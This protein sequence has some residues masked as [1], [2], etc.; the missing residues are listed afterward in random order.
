[1]ST[2]RA[3][4]PRK[5]T[6]PRSSGQVAGRTA[7]RAVPAL[8]IARSFESAPAPPVE[9]PVALAPRR[10]QPVSTPEPI[11]PAQALRDRTEGWVEIEYTVDENG[12][13]RD[14]ATTASEPHGVFDEAAMN[15]V[16]SWRYLPGVVNGRAVPQR[17]SV[18]LHF[19]VAD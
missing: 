12:A 11:Y 2:A 9:S 16:A 17:T 6:A 8:P 4:Y 15:A 14:L 10:L 18:T 5:P 7:P 19:N 13:T 1:M 3:V